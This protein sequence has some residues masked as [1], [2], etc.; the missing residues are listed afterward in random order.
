MQL[1]AVVQFA[2]VKFPS[3]PALPLGLLDGLACLFQVSP[4]EQQQKQLFVNRVFA[5]IHGDGAFVA[6]HRVGVIVPGLLKDIPYSLQPGS[7][8]WPVVCG[9]VE[10]VNGLLPLGLFSLLV[11]QLPVQPGQVQRDHRLGVIQQGQRLLQMIHGRALAAPGRQQAASRAQDRHARRCLVQGVLEE[12]LTPAPLGILHGEVCQQLIEEISGVRVAPRLLLEEFPHRGSG[13]GLQM[14]YLG[15]KLF[16]AVRIDLPGLG[17]ARL[18]GRDVVQPVHQGGQFAADLGEDERLH[19]TLR[20]VT[21]DQDLKPGSSRAQ[22]LFALV[23]GPRR[24]AELLQLA[25]VPA[26]CVSEQDLFVD[27]RHQG[28]AKPVVSG[29]EVLGVLS[30]KLQP[31]GVRVTSIQVIQH[32]QSQRVAVHVGQVP[33]VL[34]AGRE[35]LMGQ[36]MQAQVGGVGQVPQPGVEDVAQ[37]SVE[38]HRIRLAANHRNQAPALQPVKVGL[39]HPALQDRLQRI[40]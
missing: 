22:L 26:R 20:R 5:R 21:A 1:Q 25:A 38:H 19:F 14:L 6:Q 31:P 34:E 8:F 30:V 36:A 13:P 37:V 7:L 23:Q 27:H 33:G 29:D 16:P 2:Q 18:S 15:D 32:L 28:F 35:V 17:Q 9:A 24:V 12:L 4:L 10:Q 11:A 39:G 3:R 40:Q